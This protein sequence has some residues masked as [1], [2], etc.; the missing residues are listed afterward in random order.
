MIPACAEIVPPLVEVRPHHFA[1]CIRISPDQ[2]EI[3]K[4][5]AGA[6]PGLDAARAIVEA[7]QAMSS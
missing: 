3:D 2:P 6:A 1:A 4:V 7:D 5:T